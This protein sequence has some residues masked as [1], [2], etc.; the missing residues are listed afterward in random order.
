[1]INFKDKTDSFDISIRK[2]I[3]ISLKDGVFTL[4]IGDSG[5]GR[6]ERSCKV[7]K[8][9]SVRIF[10]DTSSIE[11]FVNGEVFSSRI[12]EEKDNSEDFTVVLNSSSQGCD[13]AYYILRPFEITKIS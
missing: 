10:S 3:N 4:K 13:L 6:T 7:D 12:Y 2:D 5:K 11:I 9:D 1:M 8:T